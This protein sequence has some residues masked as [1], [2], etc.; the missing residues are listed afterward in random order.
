MVA[1]MKINESALRCRVLGVDWLASVSEDEDGLEDSCSE[2][3]V[4][5]GESIWRFARGERGKPTSV[6]VDI[7]DESDVCKS[8]YRCRLPR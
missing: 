3:V 5:S 2:K 7:F 4:S 1:L 6:K 8:A